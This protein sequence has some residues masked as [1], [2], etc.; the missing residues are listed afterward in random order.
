MDEIGQGSNMLMQ[1]FRR[2]LPGFFLE[3]PDE[4]S[5]AIEARLLRQRLQGLGFAFSRFQFLDAVVDSFLIHVL[6]EVFMLLFVQITGYPIGR[7]TQ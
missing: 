5:P 6:V 1:V 3:H 7:Y 2:R 4:G